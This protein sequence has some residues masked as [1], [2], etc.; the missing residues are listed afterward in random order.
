MPLRKS[1]SLPI[2]VTPQ[3]V[4]KLKKPPP[5]SPGIETLR[6]PE[7]QPQS[8][9]GL[10]QKQASHSGPHP[11]VVL[12]K[13]SPV[14]KNQS[15]SNLS[16]IQE[17]VASGTRDRKKPSPHFI[18]P[19][20]SSSLIGLESPHDQRSISLSRFSYAKTPRLPIAG[21]LSQSADTLSST[22]S[23][24]WAYSRYPTTQGVV[25]VQQ[26]SLSGRQT[27]KNGRFNS[28]IDLN[29][30]NSEGGPEKTSFSSF[31]DDASTS[32]TLN[33]DHNFPL[34]LSEDDLDEELQAIVSSEDYPRKGFWGG[35]NKKGLRTMFCLVSLITGALGLFI[36]LPVVVFTGHT[37]GKPWGKEIPETPKLIDYNYPILKASRKDL[38]DSDTPEWAYTRKSVYGGDLRLVFSDEFNVDGRTFY[39][40]DDQ[41]WEAADLHYAYDYSNLRVSGVHPDMLTELPRILRSAT[42]YP[43]DFFRGLLFILCS[44]MTRMQLLPKMEPYRYN[45]MPFI[46]MT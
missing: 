6:L 25:S 9:K 29:R 15:V 16:A 17:G 44:G 23:R 3:P 8:Q 21:P 33:S 11:V 35:F 37:T 38:I 42:E 13:P 30:R 40:N 22:I 14:P 39:E 4:S 2:V 7:Q 1:T 34:Y 31:I 41:F 18:L 27:D 45:S 46:T 36:V 5:E 12:S 24:G 43:T 10:K 19:P 32:L 26:G 28:I 20:S